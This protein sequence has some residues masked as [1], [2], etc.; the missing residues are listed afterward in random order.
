MAK[1]L[2]TLL[3]EIGK[4]DK[5]LYIIYQLKFYQFFDILNFLS[6]IFIL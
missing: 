5:H 4:V 3:I 2:D 6:F 1:T